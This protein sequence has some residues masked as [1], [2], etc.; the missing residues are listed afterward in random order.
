[1]TQPSRNGQEPSS[2]RP[3]DAPAFP[4]KPF[5]P[6][7]F[8]WKTVII[9]LAIVV[10]LIVLSPLITFGLF[11]LVAGEPTG[12]PLPTPPYPVVAGTRIDA[13]ELI[14]STGRECPSGTQIGFTYGNKMSDQ[15]AD[16]GILEVTVQMTTSQFNLTS[17]ASDLVITKNQP[18]SS[19]WNIDSLNLLQLQAILPNDSA[20]WQTQMD[21]SGLA[22]SGLAAAST[23]H[24]PDEFYFGNFGWLTPE[25]VAARDGVD[26]IT[27]CSPP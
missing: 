13:D 24:P 8:P 6:K 2:D 14:V 21:F 20:D 16:V 12:T 4:R 11:A 1:M 9:I 27:V 17:P 22:A 25:E 18:P 15:P 23:Q 10:A 5:F 19:L 3:W 26:L 7:P